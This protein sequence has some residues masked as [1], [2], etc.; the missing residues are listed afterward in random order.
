M[1]DE[2][3]GLPTTCPSWCVGQHEQALDE[4]C[5][6]RDAARHASSDYAGPGYSVQVLQEHDAYTITEPL[7]RLEV[8]EREPDRADGS[9]RYSYATTNLSTPDLR[10]MAAQLLRLAD[11]VDFGLESRISAVER[12]R[13]PE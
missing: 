5:D 6:L 11:A 2:Y 8:R 13:A 4:G 1:N 12:D 9:P 10:R 3:A 7:L